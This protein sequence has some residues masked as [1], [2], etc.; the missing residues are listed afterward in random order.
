MRFITFIILSVVISTSQISAQTVTGLS[1]WTIFID[2][3]HSQTEN[4]GLFNYSEAQKVL[5]VGLFLRQYLQNET[6][7]D[8]V[9]MA[10]TNDDQLVGLS[11][12]TDLA[13]QLNADFYYSIHSDAS[14]PSA[15][16]TLMLHGGWRQNGQTVEKSPK[17]GKLF[18]AYMDTILTASM[19]I[20]RRG[21]YADRTFYQG[22]PENHENQWP[23]LHV[24]R[25]TNMASLLSEAGFHTN[26]YQQQR[27]INEDYKK[28]EARAAFWAILN[29]HGLAR[30]SVGIVT[31]EIKD[32]DSGAFL[33]GATVELESKSY[34]T[35]TFESIFNNYTSDPKE[36]SNGFYFLENITYG[37]QELIVS[38]ESYYPDTSIIS[39][40]DSFFTFADVSLISSRAPF[41]TKSTPAQ[42]DTTFHPST[43]L[44]LNFS[45]SMDKASVDS[46]L[47]ITPIV[48]YNTNWPNNKT[49]VITTDSMNFKTE[50][51][52]SIDSTARDISP[53]THWLDGDND[54][55]SGG[56]YVLNFKTGPEDIEPPKL[57]N[58]IPYNTTIVDPHPVI[59]VTFNELLD[60]SSI[61]SSSLE[62]GFPQ[63]PSVS[64]SIAYYDVFDRTT[65]SFFPENEL[66]DNSKYEIRVDR[67][68][69]DINGNSLGTNRKVNF[70]TGDY[71]IDELKKIDTFEAG[72][73]SWWEPQQSG[74]TE[75]I[76]T[77][78]TSRVSDTSHINLNTNSTHALRI[79]YGW[80][81]S[82]DSHLIRVYLNPG[83]TPQS[84]RFNS[85]YT[86]QAIVFGD[87][88]GNQFR[89]MLRD[90]NGQLEGSPWYTVDWYGWKQVSWDMTEDEII[91][92][93]N[94]DGVINGNAFVDSFQLTYSEDAIRNEGYIVID[95]F[96]AVQYVTITHINDTF[97]SLPDKIELSQNYP[98]PFN[99]TTTI[100]YALPSSGHVTLSLFNMLGQKVLVLVDKEI[101]AGNHALIFDALGL[102]SGIYIYQLRISNTVINKKMTLIK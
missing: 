56:D 80:K 18:G 74:S 4:Q 41:I 60:H 100:Q 10:R 46:V 53:Y 79:N 87:G 73:G 78:A 84:V 91:P 61:Q 45:R 58:V 8:T 28:L 32:K 48:Y 47:S 50:Y 76:I 39:V 67:S 22:F 49:L 7:I 36:L 57:S 40:A 64:G 94:G 72:I 12:R 63:Q 38:A 24:N 20:G 9:Y 5:R 27:N 102:S 52:L 33:N 21:N 88:S 14:G 31:G 51:T 11:Q 75:G 43:Y 44:V 29:Y 81:L 77:E 26:P 17:G 96:R 55:F 68:L 69:R 92:W 90:A 30:P 1:D 25:T 35:D 54:G 70:N 83:T 13:N 3:G 82:D 99:P 66:T 89:F 101:S 86:L 15:N 19:R 93:V 59:T 98:N 65:I 95:D 2:P 62:L 6:D 23:Y 97:T 37:E 16:S 42:N 85:T 34:T 71:I